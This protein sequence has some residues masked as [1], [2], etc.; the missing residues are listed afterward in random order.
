M[1]SGRVSGD[2][3][4]YPQGLVCLVYLVVGGYCSFL[5]QK[6]C[7]AVGV[8]VLMLQCYNCSSCCSAVIFE[9]IVQRAAS[10]SH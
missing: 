6:C 5:L 8:A 7:A 3:S 1:V 2:N 4:S 10:I 9:V